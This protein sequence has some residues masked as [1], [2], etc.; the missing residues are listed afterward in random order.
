[1]G[2]VGASILNLVVADLRRHSNPAKP[3]VSWLKR[4][5]A[6]VGHTQYRYIW[7]STT[8]IYALTGVSSP[9]GVE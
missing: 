1:M 7:W 2:A 9:I 5:G 3:M 4:A 8:S 6:V